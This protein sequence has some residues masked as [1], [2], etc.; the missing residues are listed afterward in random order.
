MASHTY[1]PN[2]G[3]NCSTVVSSSKTVEDLCEEISLTSNIASEIKPALKAVN[4]TN[5]LLSDVAE[6]TEF[7]NTFA[8]DFPESI[9]A[10]ICAP[11]GC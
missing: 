11:F 4:G 10:V 2:A 6:Q 9:Q 8:Q 3:V 5:V 7:A 1:A